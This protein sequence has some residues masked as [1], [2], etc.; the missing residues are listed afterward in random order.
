[1]INIDTAIKDIT[2]SMDYD[3]RAF[4]PRV[5][6]ISRSQIERRV[7]TYLDDPFTPFLALQFT[8]DAV[9]DYAMNKGILRD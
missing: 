3:Q 7:D 9:I 6:S 5:W 1:M 2:R 8:I 4:A